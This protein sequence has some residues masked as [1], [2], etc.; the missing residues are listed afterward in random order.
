MRHIQ[1][2][3]IHV[4]THC[5]DAVAVQAFGEEAI[6]TVNVKHPLINVCTSH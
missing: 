6:A 3:R 5:T 2:C 4:D 1:S